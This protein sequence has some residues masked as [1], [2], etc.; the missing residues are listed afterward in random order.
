VSLVLL[1]T[2]S[3][4]MGLV[5]LAAFLWAL[6]DGQ[7][8]DPEGSAWRVVAPQDPPGTKASQSHAAVRDTMRPDAA[9]EVAAVAA[10]NDYRRGAP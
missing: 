8:D 4:G 7:F 3:V 6:R 10:A 9:G 5:G 2:L 1:I